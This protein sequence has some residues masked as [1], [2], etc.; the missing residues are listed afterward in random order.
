MT[1]DLCGASGRLRDL[2]EELGVALGHWG[3]RGEVRDK[4]AARRAATTAVHLMDQMLRELYRARQQLV[5]EIRVND[6]ALAAEVDVMLAES[7]ARREA[8]S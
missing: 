5:P 4:A 8:S 2:A 3:M 6:D 7:R 1:H